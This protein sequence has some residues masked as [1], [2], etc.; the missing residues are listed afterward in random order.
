MLV[1]DIDYGESIWVQEADGKDAEYV[2]VLKDSNTCT[3]MRKYRKD[4]NDADD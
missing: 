1:S 3:F 2:C 4:L